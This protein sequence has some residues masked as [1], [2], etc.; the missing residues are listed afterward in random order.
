L[1]KGAHNLVLDFEM[2]GGY[3]GA[4]SLAWRPP[5]QDKFEIIPESYFG[6]AQPSPENPKALPDDLKRIPERN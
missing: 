2:S 3:F 1:S 5:G 4:A 6:E